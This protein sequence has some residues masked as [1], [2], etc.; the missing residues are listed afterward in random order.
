MRWIL[1]YNKYT[2]IATLLEET[3]WLSMNQLVIYHSVLIYWKILA[4]GVPKWPMEWVHYSELVE[5][6]I[7]LTG[8]TWSRI[9][10]LYF[11]RL[12]PG[13]QCEVKILRFKKGLKTW[14]LRNVPIYRQ[15]EE[16]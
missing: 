13:I 1:G 9:A 15:E 4:Y 16:I 8:K 2:S 3:G 5:N 6:R 7:H 12:D 10:P 14:I 11:N